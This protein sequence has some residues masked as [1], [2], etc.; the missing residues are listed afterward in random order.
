MKPLTIGERVRITSFDAIQIGR[1]IEIIE[2]F[3]VPQL[4]GRAFLEL[5]VYSVRLD[6]GRSAQFRGRDLERVN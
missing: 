2:P 3:V 6:D 5:P 1:I 4:K